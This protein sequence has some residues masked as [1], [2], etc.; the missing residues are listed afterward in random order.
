MA[1]MTDGLRMI[2]AQSCYRHGVF[3]ECQTTVKHDTESLHVIG[4]RQ[5]DASHRYRR[6][7]R[8]NGVQ[9]I[10]S[11]DDQCFRLVRVQLKSVLHVPPLD[12]SST[13]GK[14]GQ[15][16][17]CVVGMYG[18]MELH[19]ICVLVVLYSVAGDDI[20]HRTAV[21]CKQQWSVVPG[22][23]PEGRRRQAR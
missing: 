8:S 23:T 19:I 12:V 20:S 10:R 15:P 16:V 1:Y 9:L 3:L 14:N 22:R 5:I 6:H 18:E 21:D 13:R 2:I 17:G 7:G 11:A 4:H